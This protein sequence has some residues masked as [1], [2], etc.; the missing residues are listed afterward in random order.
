MYVASVII[1][2]LDIHCST[3]VDVPDGIVIFLLVFQFL[4][5]PYVFWFSALA[6]FCFYWAP[7]VL[8]VSTDF[9]YLMFHVNKSLIAQET[10]KQV[11]RKGT[12]TLNR[13]LLRKTKQKQWLVWLL[14]VTP[15]NNEI[16]TLYIAVTDHIIFDWQRIIINNC[17][18]VNV[19]WYL[20]IVRH[21]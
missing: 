14:T 3:N 19:I 20:K 7:L 11:R 6:N 9:W 1:I 10:R 5:I 15:V 16:F 17:R 12:R 21:E 4:V 18:G 8:F 2:C 13:W